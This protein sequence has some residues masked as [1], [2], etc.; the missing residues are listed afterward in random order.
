[1]IEIKNLELFE[2]L[3]NIKELYAKPVGSSP[4]G[5]ACSVK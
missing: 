1:M 3:V 2:S 4:W 5:S